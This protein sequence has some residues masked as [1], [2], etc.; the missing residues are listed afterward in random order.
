MNLVEELLKRMS[1]KRRRVVIIGDVMVDRWVTVRRE[2]CQDGCDKLVQ[3]SA[4]EVPGGAGNAHR[5]ISLWPVN[6]SLYGYGHNDCPIKCRYVDG[7][8]KILLRVD[9]EGELPRRGYGWCYDLAID[10]IG[11][12]S[13]VLLSDYDK[14]FLTPDIVKY[15]AN[16]CKERDIPCVADC[17]REPDIYDGCILKCNAEYQHANNQR[18]GE[19]V[20]DAKSGQRLVVT[21]G[22]LNPVMWDGDGPVGLGYDLPPV[23][24]KNHVGAGDCFAAH[25][26]LALAY[27]FSLKES[28]AIAH[29]AGRVYVQHLHNRPPRP[30]EISADMEGIIR[31]PISSA[32]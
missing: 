21:A 9:D 5:S 13:A 11:S 12:A 28:A 8:G 3:I 16:K 14:G 6:A 2:E 10:M 19:L 18:L 22:R 32:T 25:L 20:F 4:L 24:C 26:T 30:E 7:N 17:K 1:E 27:E 23:G 31:E 29:S 15:I